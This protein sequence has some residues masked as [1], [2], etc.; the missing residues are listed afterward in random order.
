M[1]KARWGERR[2]CCLE[3]VGWKQL[4]VALHRFS[5][6][7]YCDR[8]HH[9]KAKAGLRPARP[10]GR[11]CG[12]RIGFKQVH[13]WLFST[14]PLTGSP[15]LSLLKSNHFFHSQGGP[16]D[17]PQE[18]LIFSHSMDGAYFSWQTDIFLEVK[19]TGSGLTDRHTPRCHYV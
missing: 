1:I 7:C 2:V 18:V 10:S 14:S 13:F 11:D 8:H 12:A 3:T 19:I 17:L 6:I 4:H 15:K 16:N 5:G 9:Q